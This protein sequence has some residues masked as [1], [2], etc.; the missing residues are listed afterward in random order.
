MEAHLAIETE[1]NIARGMAPEGARYAAIRKLGNKTLIREEVYRMN[2]I[3]F[4]ETLWQDIRY[5]VRMLRRNPGFTAVAVMTLALG[6][7]ANTAIFSVVDGIL[8]S[9][10]P[11]RHPD[12]IVAATRNDSLMNVI[13]IQR[14]AKAFS[15]GGGI[16]VIAMDYTGGT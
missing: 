16:N 7:G 3:G 15:A 2:T 4:V 13:D 8:L 6:I 10:L 14:E 5:G 1:E 12:E 11:Y 9:P